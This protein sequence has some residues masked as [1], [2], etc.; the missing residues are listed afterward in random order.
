[1]G[2]L[3]RGGQDGL[4]RSTCIGGCCT[5]AVSR[6][7]LEL[8]WATSSEPAETPAAWLDSGTAP[9]VCLRTRDRGSMSRRD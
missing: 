2:S 7:G 4:H 5:E 6:P 8:D 1:M 3:A 9:V